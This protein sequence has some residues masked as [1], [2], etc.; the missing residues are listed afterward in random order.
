MLGAFP[1]SPCEE[2]AYFRV[3]SE[4]KVVFLT[5]CKIPKVLTKIAEDH[6]VRDFYKL[7]SDKHENCQQ[8]LPKSS[9][10]APFTLKSPKL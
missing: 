8:K 3:V 6:Q 9:F 5:L 10:L 7:P 1:S 2:L 4:P